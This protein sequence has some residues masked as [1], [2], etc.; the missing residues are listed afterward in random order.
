MGDTEV[1]AAKSL[2]ERVESLFAFDCVRLS[3]ILETAEYAV[4]FGILALFAGFGIDWV[5]RPMYPKPSKTLKGCPDEEKGYTWGQTLQVV[6]VLLL[7]V[8]VSAVLVIY[9]RKLGE[10]VPFFFEFCPSKYVPHWKVK[11]VEG[12]IAIALVYVGIQTSLIDAL[13][14]LR[15]SY[16]YVKCG[17]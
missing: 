7:Q 11:E 16:A 2:A 17:G 13:A 4:L 12:E 6:G 9:I 10:V 5:F 3:R 14:T 15:K 1:P 8:M